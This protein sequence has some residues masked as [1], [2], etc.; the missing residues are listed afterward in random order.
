MA[1]RAEEEKIQRDK[2][3]KEEIARELDKLRREDYIQE[4]RRLYEN[5]RCREGERLG[6]ESQLLRLDSAWEHGFDVRREDVRRWALGLTYRPDDHPVVLFFKV[7]PS[8]PQ[9]H[10]LAPPSQHSQPPQPPRPPPPPPPRRSHRPAPSPPSN[11]IPPPRTQ[12]EHI[13]LPPS[14]PS[15]PSPRRSRHH[16]NP[17]LPEP[18]SSSR[19]RSHCSTSK[20]TLTA[21]NIAKH[22]EINKSSMNNKPAAP[23]TSRSKHKDKKFISRTSRIKTS[24]KARVKDCIQVGA[25]VGRAGAEVGRGLWNVAVIV[26]TAI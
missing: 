23:K 26:A 4:G 13:P 14:P 18:R 20:H 3:R 1:E 10:R 15:P 5:Y 22:N 16:H 7:G 11:T 2:S 9:L 24:G 17:D 12:S 19:G 8:G 25:A 21:T 6:E